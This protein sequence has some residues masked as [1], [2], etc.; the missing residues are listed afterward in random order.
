MCSRFEQ[1]AKAKKIK[2]KFDVTGSVAMPNAPEIKPTDMALVINQMHE[3]QFLSWGFPSM[4]DGKPLFN[5]RCETL[6]QKPS[7]S[8]FL[9]QR[10]IIPATLFPEWR[11]EGKNRFRN[12]IFL[13]GAN[14]SPTVEIM[15]FA[16][17]MSSTHFT[18]ITCTAAPVMAHVHGRMPVILTAD[19]QKLWLS[20]G[21][22]FGDVRAALIPYEGDDL[23]VM[24]DT[25]I[26]PVSAQGD[27]F[28]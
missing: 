25:I 14:S 4:W 17:L 20:P 21:L 13:Q 16:G 19:N 11:K 23:C 24:E 6:E 2:K 9:E 10:C 22:N 7:F 5:A 15:G 8:S 12:S 1:D 18:I 26:P 28:Q 3:T 27:L